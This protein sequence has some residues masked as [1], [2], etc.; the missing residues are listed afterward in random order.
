M[1]DLRRVLAFGVV[2]ALAAAATVVAGAIGGGGGDEGVLPSVPRP[3]P[4]AAPVGAGDL[5]PSGTVVDL[6]G[7]ESSGG[8]EG[9]S[10]GGGA[11]GPGT[12]GTGDAAPSRIVSGLSLSAP[13]S[14]VNLSL[15]PGP[16]ARFTDPCADETR[17]DRSGCDGTT[18]TILGGPQAIVEP[19]KILSLE[20]HP[21]GGATGCEFGTVGDDDVPLL[22]ETNN[23]ADY[24]IRFGPAG[25]AREVSV[26]TGA[27]ARAQWQRWVDAGTN[28]IAFGNVVRTC[29]VLP[30]AVPRDN[31]VEIVVDGSDGITT[32]GA[33]LTLAAAR[34]RADREPV[35]ITPIDDFR[36]R[37]DVP[38]PTGTNDDVSVHLV[39]AD[40]TPE[41]GPR[42]CRGR[43]RTGDFTSLDPRNDDLSESFG[44]GRGP[45][46]YTVHRHVLR[47]DEG[48]TY[49]LC[50]WWL[51]GTD[52]VEREQ[53][54]V[55]APSRYR[56]SV[57]ATDLF[58]REA[59]SPGAGSG[60]GILIWSSSERVLC[61]GTLPVLPAG[62]NPLDR[63]V[64][65]CD[66]TAGGDV[67][68]IGDYLDVLTLSPY[69]RGGVSQVRIAIP[70]PCGRAGSLRSRSC[71]P[72]ETRSYRVDVLRRGT[73]GL[74]GGTG[75]C[76]PPR[77]H[78]Q[79]A[80]LG[81]RVDFV[82][83]PSGSG[84]DWAIDAGGIATPF[85]GA[86]PTGTT[87]ST[88]RL[89]DASTATEETGNADG[90]LAVRL[91]V[92][93][94]A[95]AS[96]FVYD[97]RGGRPCLRPG[98]TGTAEATASTTPILVIPGLCRGQSYTVGVALTDESGARAYYGTRP[99]GAPDGETVAGPI[100][101]DV[102]A[103]PVFIRA[104]VVITDIP[105]GLGIDRAFV[106]DSWAVVHLD[107]TPFGF[108]PPGAGACL[109][110]SADALETRWHT[111]LADSVD[112]EIMVAAGANHGSSPCAPNHGGARLY[113]I[114]LVGRR[115]R[116]TV[117]LADLLA[118]PVT[119]Q[120]P[121]GGGESDFGY[122]VTLETLYG[123]ST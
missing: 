44:V 55:T 82:D 68:R 19:F 63:S 80:T 1:S 3:V 65:P 116:R 87:P 90:R 76:D 14:G 41:S 72:V 107:G 57:T 123:A 100:A 43:E 98:A 8:G 73:V 114:D 59:L 81:L 110:E 77:G 29:V 60:G 83:G 34:A 30:R 119:L 109:R 103:L 10:G 53:H 94:P 26:S 67:A 9:S 47:L 89:L 70:R 36:L 79:V 91:T 71:T 85:A 37:V 86:A 40:P 33:S 54:I 16:V 52:V 46:S 11:G 2:V 27:A 12:V 5:P 96:A 113:S 84:G 15:P 17:S 20:A 62:A 97:P 64:L 49:W 121:V 23:P 21:R 66:L 22:I 51:D 95:I 111:G 92:D 75:S 24:T 56:L 117:S 31:D 4:V 35:Q 39:Q 58:V 32:D 105:D 118:G 18:G 122:T 108:D 78:V 45:R 42:S 25:L 93:R 104:F 102:S 7:G 69:S 120:S 74:C 99:A 28:G 112:V 6:A 61:H 50:I 13:P 48:T 106:R 88:P 38:R 101:A 115:I